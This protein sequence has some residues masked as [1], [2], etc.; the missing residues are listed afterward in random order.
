M[1]SVNPYKVVAD[2]ER[3]IA[4]YCGAPY[5]TAVNSCTNAIFLAL[6]WH[7]AQGRLPAEIEI[8]RF[9]YNSIP[10]QI[11]H[12]GAR[13]KFRD[14]KWSGAYH[15]TPLPIIDSARRLNAAMYDSGY[16]VCLSLHA[17]K[18]LGVEYGGVLLCD[19]AKANKWFKR[20]RFDGRTEGVEPKKDSFDACGWSFR[21]PPSAAAQ[22]LMKLYT[23]P[24]K[25][26]DLPWS[27]Y[28]DLSTLKVFR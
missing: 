4:A 22:A 27:D 14:E 3:E 11:K 9:T 12:A 15:L 8:P 10:M 19:D 23:L 24:R 13:V 2:F 16:F 21:L 18:I 17:S 25:N 26:D 6:M 5:A 28:P 7:K 20:M 1:T